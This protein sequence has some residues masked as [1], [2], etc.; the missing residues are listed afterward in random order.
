MVEERKKRGSLKID[1]MIQSLII[2]IEEAKSKKDIFDKILKFRSAKG[3]IYH[4]SKELEKLI[5]DPSYEEK[6]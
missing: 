2:D 5:N 3:R 1:G 4:I 6:A